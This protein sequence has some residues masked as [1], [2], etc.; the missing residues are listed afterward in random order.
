MGLAAD[1]SQGAEE[2]ARYAVAAAVERLD[3]GRTE[4]REVVLAPHLVLCRTMAEP[5]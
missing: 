4:P 3:Q 1:V 5:R 2:Q